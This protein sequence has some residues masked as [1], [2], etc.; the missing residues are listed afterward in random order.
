MYMPALMHVKKKAKMSYW[1]TFRY[2]RVLE[3]GT[4][5]TAWRVHV[6]EVDSVG[7]QQGH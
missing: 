2:P 4:M 7:K 6:V 3:M 1:T 5:T